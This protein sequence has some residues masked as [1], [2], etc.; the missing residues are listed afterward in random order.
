M[1]QLFEEYGLWI[2]AFLVV[3]FAVNMFSAR[4]RWVRWLNFAAIVAT[5]AA[6]ASTSFAG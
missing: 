3:Y 4:E 2:D 6:R 1:V 5:V